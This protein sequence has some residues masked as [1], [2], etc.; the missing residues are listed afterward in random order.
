MRALIPKFY[1]SQLYEPLAHA[2]ESLSFSSLVGYII[3]THW[4]TYSMLKVSSLWKHIICLWTNCI[5]IQSFLS[6]H[7]YSYLAW[8]MKFFL[9]VVYAWPKLSTKFCTRELWLVFGEML[10]LISYFIINLIIYNIY[11][12]FWG[13]NK[14]D[15]WNTFRLNMSHS[16]EIILWFKTI[17]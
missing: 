13:S 3:Y 10:Y 7:S 12:L 5:W 17:E 16:S 14:L 4:L 9:Q 8:N 1:H 15:S 6:Q 11:I 2:I